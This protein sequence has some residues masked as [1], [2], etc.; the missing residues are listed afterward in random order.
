MEKLT[1]WLAP[2]PSASAVREAHE[3]SGRGARGLD[4]TS[5]LGNEI[6]SVGDPGAVV[7]DPVFPIA[8][9]IPIPIPIPIPHRTHYYIGYVVY[10]VYMVYVV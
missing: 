3:W 6:G 10:V 4:S 9:A 5:N 2:S 8:I 1:A 7:H